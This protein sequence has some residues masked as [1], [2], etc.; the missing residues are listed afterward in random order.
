MEQFAEFDISY[1]YKYIYPNTEP[2]MSA[3]L[4]GKPHLGIDYLTPMN[5][6]IYAPENGR[7]DS[8]TSETVG[9]AVLFYDDRG[10][11]TRYLH[12]TNVNKVGKVNKGDLIGHTGNTGVSTGPHCHVD[13]WPFGKYTGNIKDTINPSFY[14]GNPYKVL[15]LANKNKWIN[16]DTFQIVREWFPVRIEFHVKHVNYDD[17]PFEK[18]FT[19]QISDNWWFNNIYTRDDI[20]MY[21]CVT[22]ILPQD[23]WDSSENYGYQK[24]TVYKKSIKRI[25][26]RSDQYSKDY[27]ALGF[28][29]NLEVTQHMRHELVHTFYDETMQEDHLHEYEYADKEVVKCRDEIDWPRIPNIKPPIEDNQ[30][31]ML[32]L[33]KGDKGPDIYVIGKDGVLM[34]IEDSLGSLNVG[35]ARGMWE[36]F[37]EVKHTVPQADI[38]AMPKGEAILI[39]KQV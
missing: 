32:K 19:T 10:G 21:D 36:Q 2:F 26:Y 37:D 14:W 28:N 12:C 20:Q 34:K 22:M 27:R 30:E 4:A 5:T 35:V 29:D 9:V 38:D 18:Q 31:D 33:V 39:Y 6:P 1:N 3:G 13:V 23:M 7:V 25:E 15:V 24:D 11:L 16:E 17:I 8:Y